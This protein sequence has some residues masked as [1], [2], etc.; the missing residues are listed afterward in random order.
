MKI[1]RYFIV[2]VMAVTTPSLAAEVQSLQAIRDA[3]QGFVEANVTTELGETVITVGELDGRLR[4][5]PCELPL[6]PY[7]PNQ[8]KPVGNITVGV[9]CEGAKPWSLLVQTRIEQFVEVVVAARPLG[10][11]QTLARSDISLARSDIS[12]LSGGYYATLEEAD[13][14]VLKRSV[15]AGMVLGTTMLTPA[16]LIK[17]GEKVMIHAE[18]GSISV[19]MEG[20]A[21]ASGARGEVIAVKN[22]S[23]QQVVE[24]E[25]VA[26]GLV[27]VRI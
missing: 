14:M 16:I 12:R 6:Q 2:V 15:T 10:R 25:V 1:S 22:L 3:V 13:G 24:A 21:Q 20:Q 17:R 27:R 19:R 7:F 4:L 11:N 8:V 26:P 18:T 23:S 9:R 5:A